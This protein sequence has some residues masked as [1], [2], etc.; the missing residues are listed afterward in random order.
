MSEDVKA[1]AQKVYEAR[2]QQ[3]RWWKRQVNMD[4]RAPQ[5][6]EVA[7]ELETATTIVEDEQRRLAHL[8]LLDLFGSAGYEENR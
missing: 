2:Q 4:S 7:D 8:V 5:W 1:Q 3:S 6:A